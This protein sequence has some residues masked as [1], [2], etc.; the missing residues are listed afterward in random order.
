M[1]Q[2]SIYKFNAT[3]TTLV[4]ELDVISQIRTNDA[5]TEFSD[6]PLLNRTNSSSFEASI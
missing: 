2:L 3:S 1:F 4:E 5:V 6:I